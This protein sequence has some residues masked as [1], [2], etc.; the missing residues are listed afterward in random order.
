MSASRKREK[1]QE[2]PASVSVLG[3]RQLTNSPQA[4]PIRNL[5]NVPGVQIQQQSAARINI[6]MRASSGV[7]GTSVFPIMDYRSLIAPGIGAFQSDAAGISNVDLERIEVVRGPGSALYGPGVTSGVVHFI[8]KSPIDYP[9][10]TMQVG[11]GELNTLITAGR[12]AWVNDNK[13]FGFKINAQYNQ[14]DEFTLDGSEGTLSSTGEFE[15][16]FD[17]FQT[18][19]VQP[20]VTDGRI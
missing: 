15:T 11:Y 5:V 1:V 12:Y 13:K 6:E 18:Q 7:F 20:V 17:K 3:A 16:Q 9:G 2:A 4:E 8:T 10:G 19:I 14:G